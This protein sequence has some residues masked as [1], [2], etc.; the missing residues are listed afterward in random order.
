M[1]WRRVYSS[2]IS[3]LTLILDRRIICNKRSA[4]VRP[5]CEETYFKRASPISASFAE[6]SGL[7]H[8]VSRSY[9]SPCQYKPYKDRA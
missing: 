8:S 9:R 2:K 7:R 1:Y 3:G 5:R 4:H 6:G